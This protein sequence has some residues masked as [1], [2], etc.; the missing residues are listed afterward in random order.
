M[1]DECDGGPGCPS[2]DYPDLNP[3]E[4][5]HPD[6]DF[7]LREDLMRGFED[8][9]FRPNASISRAMLVQMLYNCAGRPAVEAEARFSDVPQDA[10]YAAAMNWAVKRGIVRGFE[11]G[12]F[13]PDQPVTREE[14]AVMLWRYAGSP[15]VADA[16]LPFGDAAKA[17]EWALDALRWAVKQGILN[18]K[19]NGVLDPQ[20]LAT[21]A[22][23]AKMLRTFIEE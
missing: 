14:L 20:G 18:G 13:R 16:A 11:D 4:W 19:G 9:T 6:T 1:T 5:Y 17:S 2:R 10:W 7:V 15:A 23:A 21:R 3:E 12:T 8:G 22:E